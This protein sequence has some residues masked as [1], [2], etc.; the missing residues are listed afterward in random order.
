MLRPML[1]L[2]LA[3]LLAMLLATA[4][5]PD[6]QIEGQSKRPMARQAVEE[7]LRSL[8]RGDFE[9]AAR[10]WAGP[11]ENL[12]R[13]TGLDT[14]NAAE[15]LAAY[16][17][18]PGLYHGKYEVQPARMLDP[19]TFAVTVTFSWPG[20]PQAVSE[21]RVTYDGS[22]YIVLGLPPRKGLPTREGLPTQKAGEST[23]DPPASRTG[24]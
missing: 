24:S 15:L 7:Y 9:T 6:P 1:R 18:L 20:W 21:F 13:E 16:Q 17:R 2:M 10:Y 14:R 23:G 8:R 19:H 12:R 22:R 11:I 3:M 5:G 4:C